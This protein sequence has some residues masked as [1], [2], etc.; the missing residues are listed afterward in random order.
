MVIVRL[1]KH[2][3]FII[4]LIAGINFQSSA[5]ENIEDISR[6]INDGNAK[7]L[8]AHFSQSVDIGLPEN[9]QE[10]RSSQGKIVMEAF[11]ERYPPDSFTVKQQGSTDALSS[12]FI[13]KYTSSGKQFQVLVILKKED[14]NYLIHKLKFETDDQ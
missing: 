4:I 10:Y 2:L 5:Q 7:D 11:F 13:G 8:S 12:F 3:I 1:Y 14:E 6:A 9:D